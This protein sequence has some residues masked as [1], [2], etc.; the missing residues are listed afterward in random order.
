[1]SRIGNAYGKKMLFTHHD[2]IK[3]RYW[4]DDWGG[5]CWFDSNEI[6]FAGEPKRK[7]RFLGK[8]GKQ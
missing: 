8:R 4:T 3:N 7:S 6:R 2:P 5:G 1:M